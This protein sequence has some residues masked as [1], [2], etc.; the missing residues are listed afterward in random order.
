MGEHKTLHYLSPKSGTSKI[1]I[2]GYAF[3]DDYGTCHVY[4]GLYFS[5]T[6]MKFD[7]HNRK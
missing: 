1:E 2:E 3:I 4:S 7:E 5:E 6:E